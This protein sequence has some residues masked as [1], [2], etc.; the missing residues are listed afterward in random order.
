MR[1]V[2]QLFRYKIGGASSAAQ[3]LRDG[4]MGEE[5]DREK[6]EEGE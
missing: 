1:F 3:V 2:M 4:E 6:E 5:R